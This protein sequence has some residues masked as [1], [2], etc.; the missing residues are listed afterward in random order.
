[1]A[2]ASPVSTASRELVV[3][4]LQLVDLGV[5]DPLGG[6][7]R[8]APWRSWPA[9]RRCPRRRG[10]SAARRRDRGAARVCTMPSPRSVRSA[11]RTGVM[12]TPSC[13]G[14][15]V[16]PDERAGQQ[17]AGHDRRP[18]DARRP[19]RTV[20]SRRT[21]RRGRRTASCRC[22]H[23]ASD[24]AGLSPDRRGHSVTGATPCLIKYQRRATRE[25]TPLTAQP[26]SAT[27][28]TQPSPTD[29]PYLARRQNWTNQLA[30]HALMQPDAT[31]L[32]FLGHTTTLG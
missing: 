20:C 29:Q 5:G 28:T 23:S 18:A 25:L 7:R 26:R 10:G 11:S 14:R 3:E 4:P 22:V 21:A 12:L 32:R 13:A 31:A 1:M 15:L 16:E 9:A 8:R 27:A 17:R 19:R 30:R 24:S 6:G 2:S